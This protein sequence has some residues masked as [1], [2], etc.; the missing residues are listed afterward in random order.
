MGV[1]FADQFSLLH[2]ASGVIAYFWGVSFWW[3]FMLH[4]L[5]EYG[6]NT[7]HGMEIIN[8]RLNMWPGGKDS[9]D[10]FLNSVGDQFFGMLGWVMA[11]YLDKTVKGAPYMATVRQG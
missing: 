10:S 4:L 8:E 2:A 6:E 7:D 3:W 1:V 11:A 5:F 9:K